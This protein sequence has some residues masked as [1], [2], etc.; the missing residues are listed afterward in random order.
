MS[1]YAKPIPTE[2]FLFVASPIRHEHKHL[3]LPFIVTKFD[4][5]TT[6]HCEV[7]A[8]TPDGEAWLLGH[9]DDVKV[10]YRMIV[11]QVYGMEPMAWSDAGGRIKAPSGS[12]WDQSLEWLPGAQAETYALPIGKT[13]ETS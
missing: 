11:R 13:E 12:T 3:R 9:L 5:G 6:P 2:K 4:T 7:H 8:M 1:D 10:L